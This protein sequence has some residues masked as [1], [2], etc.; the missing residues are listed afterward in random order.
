MDDTTMS[1]SRLLRLPPEIR[2]QIW[3]ELLCPPGGLVVLTK[4]NR[5]ARA[6]ADQLSKTTSSAGVKRMRKEWTWEELEQEEEGEEEVE[7]EEDEEEGLL[8]DG[9]AEENMIFAE[10]YQEAKLD[11]II[12]AYYEEEDDDISSSSIVR[13]LEYRPRC[14]TVLSV[15]IL[16]VNNQVYGECIRVFY[17]Q[18]T[19]RFCSSASDT[20]DFLAALRERHRKA[21]RHIEFPP[22]TTIL[23]HGDNTQGWHRLPDFISKQMQVN[24]VTLW[25]PKD[26]HE[27][28]SSRS[29]GIPPG[30]L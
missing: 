25:V 24:T 21:I 14:C 22:T 30:H 27:A 4:R 6:L 16:R 28:E 7:A 20:Q 12:D 13:W 11:A 19:F 23:N 8:E 9:E 17:R 3:R 18:N 10:N 29:T 26:E 5:Q 15:A 2:E 1:G